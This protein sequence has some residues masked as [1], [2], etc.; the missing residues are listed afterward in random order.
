MN[1]ASTVSG[2]TGHAAGPTTACLLV[3]GFAGSAFELEHFVPPLRELG[4]VTVLPTLPGHNATIPEFLKTFYPDWL[5]HV[6]NHLKALQRQYQKVFLIGFSMGA[7]ICLTLATRYQLAGLVALSTPY[8]AYK[9]FPPRRSSLTVFA[10]I[11]SLIRPVICLNPPR[12]ESRAIAPFKGYEGNL[13]LPQVHSMEAGLRAMRKI[14]PYVTCP[15]LMLHD[16]RDAICPAENAV[17]VAKTCR[18]EDLTFKFTHIRERITK[19]HMITTHRETRDLVV[20]EAVEFVK[21]RM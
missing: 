10:P 18:S 5:G 20:R 16:L 11:L 2:A 9:L 17:R 15:M 14:L 8:Q 12:P 3:H 21:S 4:C 7:A 1:S 6:E 19:H 13:C